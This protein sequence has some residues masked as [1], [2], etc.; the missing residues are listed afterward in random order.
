MSIIT[1]ARARIALVVL[2]FAGGFGGGVGVAAL[3]QQPEVVTISE[4]VPGVCVQAIQSATEAIAA[5]RRVEQY[6]DKAAEIAGE[7]TLAVAAGDAEKMADALSPIAKHNEEE[8]GW[9]EDRDSAREA[10]RYAGDDCIAKHVA[11]EAA[12]ERS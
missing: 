4:A 10:F 1:P 2:A 3:T 5:E 9:R 6:D 11:A 7:V 8:Q 12:A